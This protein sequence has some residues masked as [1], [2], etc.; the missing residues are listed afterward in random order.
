MNIYYFD[1]SVNC[2]LFF[3]SLTLSFIALY[4]FLPFS[5]F[6]HYPLTHFASPPSWL[7]FF[8]SSL[9][10]PYFPHTLLSSSLPQLKLDIML[11]GW[12]CCAFTPS[13][14]R[15]KVPSGSTIMRVVGWR[16]RAASLGASALSCLHPSPLKQQGT[17]PAACSYKTDRSSRR[18]R[19][20]HCP[21]KVGAVAR[22][23]FPFS[24]RSRVSHYS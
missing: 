21:L 16:C 15:S 7:F 20:S 18:S 24:L 8:S 12:S 5:V 22:Q 3:I 11:Q 10:S 2:S 1:P 4:L 17:T 23:M 14:P 13:C 9:I 19:L 6:T